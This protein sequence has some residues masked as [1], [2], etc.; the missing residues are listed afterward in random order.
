[1]MFLKCCAFASTTAEFVTVT[2]MT[3]MF[4]CVNLHSFSINSKVSPAITEG[5]ALQIGKIK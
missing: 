5:E 1:M 2:G 3:L 4:M